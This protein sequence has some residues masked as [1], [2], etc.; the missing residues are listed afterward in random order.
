MHTVIL[1]FQVVQRTRGA[2]HK[3][4]P[5]TAGVSGSGTK[6]VN[7]DTRLSNRNMLTADSGLRLVELR[8]TCGNVLNHWEFLGEEV[9][10]TFTVVAPESDTQDP[11][12]K[13]FVLIAVDIYGNLIHKSI[14]A[15]AF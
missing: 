3:I 4:V 9:P 11:K 10:K 5:Q 12:N 15:S 13:V 6:V 8:D 2:E 14:P 7:F 1:A